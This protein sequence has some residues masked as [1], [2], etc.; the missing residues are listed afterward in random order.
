MSRYGRLRTAL[1]AIL[2]A[3][4]RAESISF[5]AAQPR[6]VGR[7]RYTHAYPLYKFWLHDTCSN[8]VHKF[9]LYHSYANTL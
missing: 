6:E 1:P 4:V 3:G 8:A 5:P 9:R 7:R 2:L